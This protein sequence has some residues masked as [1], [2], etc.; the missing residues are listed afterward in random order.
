MMT[1]H[2]PIRSRL[3]AIK[4]GTTLVWACLGSFICSPVKADDVNISVSV[5]QKNISSYDIT[6]KSDIFR[7]LGLPAFRDALTVLRRPKDQGPLDRSDLLFPDGSSVVYGYGYRISG[8]AIIPYGAE[9]EFEKRYGTP[10][11]LVGVYGCDG[12]DLNCIEPS[13]PAMRIGVRNTGYSGILVRQ[14]AVKV[15]KSERD[16]IPRFGVSYS[17]GVDIGNISGGITLVNESRAALKSA[18]LDFDLTCSP[19]DITASY[20]LNPLHVYQFSQSTKIVIDYSDPPN[21]L[22]E[23][24]LAPY[25]RRHN[26]RPR[27]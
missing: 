13:F 21:P 27:V 11:A 15:Q 18:R 23:V 19:P 2:R 1:I 7:S 16:L 4:V 17:G 10:V 24:K 20:F 8:N 26:L 25:R 9:F 12:I 3:Y 5:A 22:E 6:E 14:I